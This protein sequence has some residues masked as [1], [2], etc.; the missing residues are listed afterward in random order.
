MQILFLMKIYNLAHSA[1]VLIFLHRIPGP[2]P[3]VSIE[4]Y[5]LLFIASLLRRDVVKYSECSRYLRNLFL[6]E[7]IPIDFPLSF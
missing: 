4:F 6:L 3:I 1:F 7:N 5:Q 2:R